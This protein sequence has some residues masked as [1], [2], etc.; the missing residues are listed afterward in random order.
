MFSKRSFF[1]KRLPSAHL[2]IFPH[3]IR[4]S[5]GMRRMVIPGARMQQDQQE[6]DFMF[7][8]RNQND[9]LRSVCHRNIS[10]HL[11]AARLVKRLVYTW[12]RKQNRSSSF[13][14]AIIN[15][16]FLSSIC[17]SLSQ[18]WITSNRFDNSPAGRLV[19]HFSELSKTWLSLWR[20]KK[21]EKRNVRMHFWSPFSWSLHY[22]NSHCEYIKKCYFWNIIK[23]FLKSTEV[24]YDFHNFISIL[25]LP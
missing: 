19:S 13:V 21:S 25:S 5:I 23:L 7:R 10:Q 22:F 16:H 20:D 24:R 9:D 12:N 4:R 1:G 14:L 8:I 18:H 2:F 6:N 3:F 17:S 11:Y 15:I